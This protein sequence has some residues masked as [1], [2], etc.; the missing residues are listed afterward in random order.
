[1]SRLVIESSIAPVAHAGCDREAG[2]AYI[3]VVVVRAFLQLAAA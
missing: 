2:P 3:G 1:M